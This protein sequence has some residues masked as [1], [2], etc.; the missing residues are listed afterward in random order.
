MRVKLLKLYT[1]F[2]LCFSLSS[3]ACDIPRDKHGKI[4][5]NMQERKHFMIISGYPK[6]RPGYV[7]DHIIPLCA[8]G[9]DVAE[10]MQWQSIQES[11]LKD[12]W[13][14]KQCKLKKS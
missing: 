14:R 12:K 11:K 13:E 6:G 7:V 2:L 3:Y 1:V 8:C 5:R 9:R 10:N 4:K